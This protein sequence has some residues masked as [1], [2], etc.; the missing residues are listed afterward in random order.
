MKSIFVEIIHNKNN[1]KGYRGK[2]VYYF[3]ERTNYQGIA[4]V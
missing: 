1:V 4:K 3:Q 2:T